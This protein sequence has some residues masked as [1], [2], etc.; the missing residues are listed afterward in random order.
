M[1][2]DENCQVGRFI[3][4]LMNLTRSALVGSCA[5]PMGASMMLGLHPTDLRYVR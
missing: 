2:S 5:P 4:S 1:R 3:S